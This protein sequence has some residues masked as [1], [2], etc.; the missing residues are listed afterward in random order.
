MPYGFPKR[1]GG[2]S[3]ENDAKMADCVNRVVASGRDKQ[4]A[5][6]ICKASLIKAAARRRG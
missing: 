3:P 5:I 6:R 2:D 4:S 1:Y